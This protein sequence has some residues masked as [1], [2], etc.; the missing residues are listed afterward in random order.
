MG[1]I[2]WQLCAR[3]GYSVSILDAEALMLTYE[4]TVE[5]ILELQPA[6]TVFVV[7]GQQPSAS[8]QSMPAAGDICRLV[9]EQAPGLKTVFMG[10]IIRFA[11]TDFKRR[12][13]GF[14]LSGRRPLDHSLL[15]RGN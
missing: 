3:Q 5:Q 2:D 6:L 11:G 1:S 8:T 4:Q 7:Y 14:C 15:T 10:T 13:H 9:K 12:G